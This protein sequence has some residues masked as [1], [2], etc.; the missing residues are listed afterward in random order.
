MKQKTLIGIGVT[1]LILAGLWWLARI[2]TN[3]TTETTPLQAQA[4][5]LEAI[6]SF[7]DFGTIRMVN[8][9]ASHEF[10]VMNRG[11]TPVTIR[12]I[13]TSCMC[14]TALLIRNETNL[15]PFGMPGHAP[16]PAISEEISPG[17]EITIA[18]IFDPT[19]HGPAGVGQSNRAIYLETK[20]GVTE[21]Q[22]TVFVE[23]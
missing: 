3:K 12:K 18:A 17:E 6:E 22:F 21:L 14:T 20:N 15:G 2:G 16:I 4:S 5:E 11:V 8:G 19:A 9:N 10:R 1:V 13:Y 23:P 7:Y